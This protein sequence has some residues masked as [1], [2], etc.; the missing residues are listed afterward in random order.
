VYHHGETKHTI[1]NPDTLQFQVEGLG[2][3]VDVVGDV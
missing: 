2:V 1:R 3:V